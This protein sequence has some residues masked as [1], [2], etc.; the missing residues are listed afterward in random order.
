MVEYTNGQF[1]IGGRYHARRWS[2]TIGLLDLQ[3]VGGGIAYTA[4]LR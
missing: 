3:R 4:A 1:N 2:A